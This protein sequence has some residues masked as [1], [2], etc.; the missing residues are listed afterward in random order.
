MSVSALA[1]SFA[2]MQWD[3]LKT[4]K[5][6]FDAVTSYYNSRLAQALHCYELSKRLAGSC[7]LVTFCVVSL[8]PAISVLNSF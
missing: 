8:Q 3:D 7:V 2:E 4:G 5:E 6:N 1:Y